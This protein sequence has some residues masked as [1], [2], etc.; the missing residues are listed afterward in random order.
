[1]APT[2]PAAYTAAILQIAYN[3]G[4]PM[5]LDNQKGIFNS[6]GMFGQMMTMTNPSG[7]IG[8]S[9]FQWAIQASRGSGVG[10]PDQDD[11]NRSTAKIYPNSATFETP[12]GNIRPNY[13]NT[14]TTENRITL[15]QQMQNAAMYIDQT[16]RK[17]ASMPFQAL[18]Y[19]NAGF[20]QGLFPAAVGPYAAGDPIPGCFNGYVSE[21]GS[22]IAAA[23]TGTFIVPYRQFIM[24]DGSYDCFRA[25]GSDL[26]LAGQVYVKSRPNGIGTATV[27]VINIGS[28][29]YTPTQYDL[30]SPINGYAATNGT[31]LNVQNM[32]PSALEGI[33]NTPF[34]RLGTTTQQ[35]DSDF[36]DSVVQDFNAGGGTTEVSRD[37]FYQ[38]W[39]EVTNQLP[40]ELGIDPLLQY[41]KPGSAQA[42][43]DVRNMAFPSFFYC[44]TNYELPLLQSMQTQTRYQ[45]SGSQ[46]QFE[47]KRDAGLGMVKVM[48]SKPIF[49]NNMAPPDCLLLLCTKTLGFSYGDGPRE[50][51]QFQDGYTPI[52]QT[53]MAEIQL[54]WQAQWVP[55][56]RNGNGVYRGLKGRGVSSLPGIN[57]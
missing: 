7:Q 47:N 48:D 27:T 53:D 52:P 12:N 45:V 2:N 1:M 49:F 32:L 6:I 21:T 28:G 33:N 36:Y 55:K 24:V 22:A 10:F 50:T 54:K 18:Q 4:L 11:T 34:P 44:P 14:R 9:V 19:L 42:P 51:G 8:G 3:A 20:G 41:P 25:S 26:V 56:L 40:E 13:I 31:G 39:T 23:A 43:N 17:V 16:T 57:A 46:S 5:A 29:S 15:G 37:D 38:L 35:L 30:L